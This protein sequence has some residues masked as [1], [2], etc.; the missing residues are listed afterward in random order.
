MKNDLHFCPSHP[1]FLLRFRLTCK[2]WQNLIWCDIFIRTTDESRINNAFLWKVGVFDSVYP[3]HFYWSVLFHVFV[4]IPSLSEML[5]FIKYDFFKYCLLFFYCIGVTIWLPLLF[6]SICLSVCLSVFVCACLLV[7]ISV[8][9]LISFVV[10]AVCLSARL[11][12]VLSVYLSFSLFWR[13]KSIM[14]MA[15]IVFL[16]AHPRILKIVKTS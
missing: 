2:W 5:S 13:L 8:C 6:I 3:S 15:S 11:S 1:R 14:Q 12:F 4:L 16:C 9:L 10:W 7:S